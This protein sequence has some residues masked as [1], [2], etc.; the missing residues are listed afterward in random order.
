MLS[1]GNMTLIL[2]QFFFPRWEQTLATW[3]NLNPNYAEVTDWYSGWKTMLSEDLLAQPTIKEH[4]Q[5][6]LVIMNRAVNIGAQPGAKE[7]ISY[8][9]SME[10][11]GPPPP[12]P[13]SQVEVFFLLLFLL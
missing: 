4:F 7:S 12:P 1:V 3:L 11:N 8:L 2:D 13:P 6:A 10:N 9:S 5:K